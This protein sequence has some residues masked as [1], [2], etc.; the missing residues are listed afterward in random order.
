MAGVG[1]LG[2]FINTVPVRLRVDPDARANAWLAV[3]SRSRWPGFVRDDRAL[4]D[5]KLSEIEAGSRFSRATDRHELPPRRAPRPRRRRH[6]VR[7]VA[8]YDQTDVPL[9]L[10][11]TQPAPVARARVR[12][13]P[14]RRG[15]DRILGRRR[16]LTAF[17]DL[18]RPLSAFDILERRAHGAAT[19]F[20]ATDVPLDRC[21]SST[22]GAPGQS[23]PDAIAL[24]DGTRLTAAS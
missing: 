4:R 5:Q 14:L 11:V 10:Q 12:Q 8:T 3:F 9:T 2:V 21:R 6:R 1:Q 13:L 18:D 16:L 7:D 20:N 19:T 15:D 17:R 23:S 24:V 22:P